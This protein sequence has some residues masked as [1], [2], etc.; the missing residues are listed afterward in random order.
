MQCTANCGIGVYPADSV[1]VAV[2]PESFRAAE[3]FPACPGCGALA[4][5]NVLMFGDHEWD[6]RRS[7]G[8][9]DRLND[10]MREHPRGGRRLAVIEC[11]A[12]RAIPTIGR[13]CEQA[14]GLPRA[15]FIRLNPREPEVPAGHIGLPMGALDGLRAIASRMRAL[16]QR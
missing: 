16:K 4:R 8:Q 10:W 6:S 7:G 2:D 1:S 15:T 9:A 13:M 11:G 12:G 5:P 14:A 3:P